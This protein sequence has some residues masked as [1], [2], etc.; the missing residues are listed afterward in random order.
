MQPPPLLSA[1]DTHRSKRRSLGDQSQSRSASHDS[2]CSPPFGPR[3]RR[4]AFLPAS[5][6]NIRPRRPFQFPRCTRCAGLAFLRDGDFSAKS[7]T[8]DRCH[9]SPGSSPS[10]QLDDVD[11]LELRA[12]SS[13]ISFRSLL[14]H[15]RRPRS[16]RKPRRRAAVRTMALDCMI[17]SLADGVDGFGVL[18]Y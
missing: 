15:P 16:M 10:S 3:S 5:L 6:G 2:L 1:A 14:R 9:D 18:A 13:S 17:G 11:T 12:L 7:L 4:E 8:R